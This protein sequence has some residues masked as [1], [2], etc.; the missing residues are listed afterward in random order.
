MSQI[1]STI[2]NEF[3]VIYFL[4]NQGMK[5]FVFSIYSLYAG[6]VSFSVFSSIATPE[7][8]ISKIVIKIEPN[9]GI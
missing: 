8:L 1:Y 6:F 3:I 2:G 9:T 7:T 5:A 4:G